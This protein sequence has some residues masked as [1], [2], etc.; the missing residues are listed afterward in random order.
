MCYFISN[1]L[2]VFRRLEFL[3]HIFHGILRFVL[4]NEK[5]NLPRSWILIIN[6]VISGL[7]FNRLI[8]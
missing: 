1:I 7:Y 5:L 6:K 4:V 8:V 3:V 2:V